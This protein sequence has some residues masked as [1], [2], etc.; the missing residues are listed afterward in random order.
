MPT[1]EEMVNKAAIT[2]A[3]ALATAGKLNDEQADKFIDYV[4]DVTGVKAYARVVRFRAENMKIDK[5]GV[6]S[7]VTMPVAEARDPGRRKGITT[8]VITLTP[9][10]I[11]TPFEIGDSFIENN[12]EGEAVEDHIVKMMATQMG[13][14]VE[15]LHVNGDSLGHAVIESDLVDGGSSTDYIKDTFL[16]LFSGWLRLADGGNL[17][18]I[19]GEAISA[20]VFSRMLNAMPAKFKRNKRNLVFI[21]SQEME[22]LY[23]ERTA[24]RATAMGDAALNGQGSMTPFGVELVGVPLFQFYP[25][26]VEHITFTGSGSAKALR[27]GPIQAGSLVVTP[28][29]LDG[30]NPQE[31]FALTTDYTV[32]ETTGVVTHA[33]GGSSIGATATVKAT[34]NAWPQILLTHRDNMIIGW[35]RDIRVEKDRDIYARVNQ[36][37]ITAKTDCKFEE[38]SAVVKAYNI[39]NAI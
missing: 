2:A 10:E 3:D 28:S 9:Q 11:M 32:N 36:Y 30:S 8:S 13:N 14:D 22:Q 31:A 5:I 18:D 15:E 19:A 35:G 16:G 23:R 12:L 26:V 20:N 37:A 27:Y 6:G 29:D 33:G 25:P 7:R 39:G 34:Y 17:V 21:T 38:L 24:T 4:I 1:N